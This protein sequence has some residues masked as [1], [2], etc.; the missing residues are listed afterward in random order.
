VRTLLTGNPV[1]SEVTRIA[2]ELQ[3]LGSGEPTLLVLGGSQGARGVNDAVLTA[4]PLLTAELYGWRVVHQTGESDAARV[5]GHY[6][7]VRPTATVAAFLDDLPDWYRRATVVVSRA[8]ATTLAE[9]AC[10]GVP[11][12]LVPFPRAADG[13]QLANAES[14]ANSRAAAVVTER[15]HPADTAASLAETLR[16]LL[17]DPAA[18]A[19]MRHAL[20]SRARPDAAALV[21]DC[22]EPIAKCAESR[23]V[24]TPRL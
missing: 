10:V 18:R 15:P 11:T 24:A 23:G 17:C 3:P 5:G 19:R 9:L 2:E 1:R 21:A 14:F 16:P 20:R 6:A 7:A 22:L 13:H 12:V 8:G 4:L